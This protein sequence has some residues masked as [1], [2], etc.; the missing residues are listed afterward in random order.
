MD[1]KEGQI[2]E[3]DITDV[4]DDGK[5]LAGQKTWLFLWKGQFP[6]TGFWQR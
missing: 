3:L 4:S 2:I 6:E 5:G 1:I